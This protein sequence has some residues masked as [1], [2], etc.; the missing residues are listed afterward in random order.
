MMKGKFYEKLS[1]YMLPFPD[2][3]KHQSVKSVLD[4]AEKEFEQIKT[5]LKEPD[6]P[7]MTREFQVLLCWNEWKIKWFGDKDG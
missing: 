7:N 4:E 6:M 5:L 2:D 3:Q 1:C